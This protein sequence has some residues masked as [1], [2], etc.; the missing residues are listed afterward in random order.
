MTY[1]VF[2][3]KTAQE[4]W[5]EA[6]KFYASRDPDLGARFNSGVR[7]FLNTLRADPDRFRLVSRHTRKAR[8]TEWP[9][10]A[11]FRIETHQRRVVVVA[12]WHG[13]RD[14]AILNRR[15]ARSNS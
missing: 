12:I 4:E 1:D 15:L 14:P 10:S 5:A 8:M 9:Y 2:V 3:D 6:A 7:D 13:H 11:Y